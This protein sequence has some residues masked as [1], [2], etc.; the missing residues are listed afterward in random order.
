WEMAALGP[1]LIDLAA[2]SAGSWTEEQRRALAEV[3]YAALAP[4]SWPEIG[5]LLD[6]LDYCRLHLAVQWLGWSDVWSPP[7][8]RAHDWLSEAFFL[9]EKIGL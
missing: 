6:A 7:P 2:L 4:G 8:E 9:M 1:G 3:Y 5:A